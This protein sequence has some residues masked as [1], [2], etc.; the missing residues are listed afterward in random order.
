MDW[1]LESLV[2]WLSHFFPLGTET[3]QPTI[4][5]LW[6][7]ILTPFLFF[8]SSPLSLQGLLMAPAVPPDYSPRIMIPCPPR[9]P[10]PVGHYS[11][12]SYP[13]MPFPVQPS[14]VPI[15]PSM[16]IE[17]TCPR[18]STEVCF[19]ALIWLVGLGFIRVGLGVNLECCYGNAAYVHIVV[20]NILTNRVKALKS[21]SE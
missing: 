19:K 3:I 2:E 9:T 1:L 4:R 10:V 14:S 13:V 16:F 6:N 12:P 11:L 15:I 18:Y 17:I 7:A 21:T 8:S 5:E 20:Y